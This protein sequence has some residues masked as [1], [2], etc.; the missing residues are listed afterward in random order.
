MSVQKTKEGVWMASEWESVARAIAVEA[1]TAMDLDPDDFRLRD[2]VIVAIANT[3]DESLDSVDSAHS[4]L[5]KV[6]AEQQAE[7]AALKSTNEAY[8]R[9]LNVAQA[10][11]EQLHEIHHTATDNADVAKL[12]RE[13]V[14][15]WDEIAKETP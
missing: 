7:L 15:N 6:V 14:N 12:V 8:S 10:R 9:C 4:A 5:R 2:K 1:I 3:V 13:C 11:W